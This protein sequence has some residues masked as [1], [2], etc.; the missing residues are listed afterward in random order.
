MATI[1][2]YPHQ[3]EV[4]PRLHNKC[5]LYGGTGSG[6]SRTSL[7]YYYEYV[8]KGK[9]KIQIY[10]TDGSLI[11][12]VGTDKNPTE[13]I[14]LLI[15]TTPQK[16]DKLEW[17]EELVPFRLF[18]DSTLNPKKINVVIDSWNNIKKYI[19]PT[20]GWFIIFDEQRLTGSGTW[21]KSFLK[22]SRKNQW[23]VL[24]ATPGDSYYEYV[25][26]FIANGFVKNKQEFNNDFVIFDPYTPFPK[27][28]EYRR[29]D[30][31]DKLRDSILISMPDQRKTTQIHKYIECEYDKDL[32]RKIVDKRWDPWDDK[33]IEETGK[34][35]YLMR[36][37]PN[38]DRS[39]AEKLKELIKS[40]KKVIVFYNF[41]YELEMIRSV[42]SELHVF[43]SEWNGEAH[44]AIGT[45]STWVYAVQYMGCEGWNCI[46]TNTII[47][48][49]QTYSY[50]Q[51]IQ[52][53]GRIDRIDTKFT[54]LY[55]Y[56]LVSKCPIDGSIRLALKSKK[57]F[58]ES[59]YIRSLGTSRKR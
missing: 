29:T 13:K 16:R 22:L 36:K 28:K 5:V 21:V 42:C 18:T 54:D 33:P 51:M 57:N 1:K 27:I 59:A 46:T 43:F 30:V 49:S 32:Y 10:N 19:K 15:I 7:A 41:T 53:A 35:C 58:N 26:L 52:A 56:H 17:E 20:I 6:K 45:G 47:F 48:L 40:S 25:P 14:D 50:K 37:V 24:S 4:L 44:T 34:L 55:Y 23:M 9:L 8:I 31:L 3:E 38:S 11:K 12:T 2:L 39:R